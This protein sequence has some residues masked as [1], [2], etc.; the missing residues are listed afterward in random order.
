MSSEFPSWVSTGEQ[1]NY[2]AQKAGYAIDYQ[3]RFS[4]AIDAHRMGD[5]SLLDEFEANDPIL[6]ARRRGSLRYLGNYKPH[7]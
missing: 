4:Q 2:L 6:Q 3:M 1:K 7:R 5:S